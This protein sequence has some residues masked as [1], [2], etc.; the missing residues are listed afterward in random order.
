VTAHQEHRVAA[1]FTTGVV[2]TTVSLALFGTA[3]ATVAIMR[4]QLLPLDTSERGGIAG[5][6]AGV[7]VG[8]GVAFVAGR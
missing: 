5:P 6:A 7:S 4:P 2:V 8:I 3:L 1:C